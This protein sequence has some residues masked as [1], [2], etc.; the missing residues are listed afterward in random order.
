MTDPILSDSKIE[1][2][3]VHGQVPVTALMYD[4][5]LAVDPLQPTQLDELTVSRFNQRIADAARLLGDSPLLANSIDRADAFHCLLTTIHSAIDHSILQ[6]DTREPMF[7]PIMPTHRVDWGARN[8]DGVYRRAYVSPDR[9]YRVH[10]RL[11]NAKYFTFDFVGASYDRNVGYGLDGDE[12]EAD[13]DG[14]FE[15]F[16]G[17]PEQPQRWYPMKPFV[18]AVSTR[19]FF[20]DWGSAERAVLRIDCMDADV[21]DRTEPWVRPEHHP[22]RVAAEFDVIGDWV[23]EAGTRY[24]LQEWHSEENGAV[25]R[26]RFNDFYRTET[27]RPT[28]CRGCWHLDDD[29]ALIVEF[30][31]PRA[32][33]WGIQ[34]SSIL[35][36]TLDF[37]SRLTTINNAQSLVDDDG[38]IRIVV[39]HRDPGVHNWLDTMSLS[40]G[41]LMMR[42]HQA[43]TLEP[44]ETRIVKVME[45]EGAT[46][47]GGT[48]S[49]EHRRAQIAERREG[50]A[51]LLCD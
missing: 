44:P 5:L 50:V 43:E 42:V 24:W 2:A 16:L 36:H 22:A 25:T 45:M 20:D 38:R 51:H 34:A 18:Q 19:E 32:R 26:N 47:F 3:K 14:H 13:G 8:P 29:E 4:A 6:T 31:D 11:G 40:H 37:A 12:L 35:V 10:G 27:K 39:S 33:Y 30:P 7:S 41:D 46:G 15:F 48:V 1:F 21:L 23:Y 9:S 17:G 28:V 49:P